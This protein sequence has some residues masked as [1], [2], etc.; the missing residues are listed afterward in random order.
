MPTVYARRVRA[1]HS[2][3]MNVVGCATAFDYRTALTKALTEV[4]MISRTLEQGHLAPKDDMM[5]CEAIHDGAVFMARPEYAHAFDFFDNNGSVTLPELRQREP[6]PEDASV[7]ERAVWLWRQLAALG[8][9]IYVA[10]LTCDE[11]RDVGLGCYRVVV[12]QLMPLSLI[13]RARFLG[14][15]RP[16]MLAAKEGLRCRIPDDINPYPQP[17][18]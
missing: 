10:N 5:D 12:P 15:P 11:L 18:A 14:T 8:M 6:L 16:A 13:R 1:G 17:F 3:V 4:V 7:S 2:R 9:D